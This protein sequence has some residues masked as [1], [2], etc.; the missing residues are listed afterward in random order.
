VRKGCNKPNNHHRKK[1]DRPIVALAYSHSCLLPQQCTSAIQ[2]TRLNPI[3]CR[4]TLI[5]LLYR[6]PTTIPKVNSASDGQPLSEATEACPER[7]RMGSE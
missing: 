4:T 5:E 6:L 1:N 2:I 3:L 7:S